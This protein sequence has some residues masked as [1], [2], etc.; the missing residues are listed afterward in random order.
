MTESWRPD[1]TLP[2]V[3]GLSQGADTASF[4]A[5]VA[6]C[7]RH[8]GSG[9][10][11][12]R[13]L[14]ALGASEEVTFD[15]LSDRAGRFANVLVGRGVR[16]GDRV[17]GLIPRIPDLLTVILGTLRVGA[18]YQ[19][20]FTAFGPKAIAS[21]LEVSCPRLVV[22]DGANRSKLAGLPYP[23]LTIDPSDGSEGLAGELAS[24]DPNFPP[25]MMTGADPFLMMFTSG[26]T[27]TPK[28]VM[29]PNHMLRAVAS[30]IHYGLDLRDND[31][32]WNLADPGWAY[33][34]YYG[35]LGP[36]LMGNACT[37]S[38][39]TFSVERSYAVI[40]RFGITNL[41][42]APTAYRQM[43]ANPI[44]PPQGVRV[45]SSAGETLDPE[46]AQWLSTSFACPA[47]DHFGQTEVG[48]VLCDHHGLDQPR[49]PGTVGL[50]VPGFHV[51]VVSRNGVPCEAGEPGLLAV[52]R[53]SPLFWFQGYY[54]GADA[55]FAGDYYLTGDNARQ[56][57]DGTFRFVG[58]EDDVITSSGY[59]IGPSEV[60]NA[61]MEH[62]AVLDTAVI[63]K[64]DPVRT[65]L[66]K[67]FVVLKDGFLPSDALGE[68]IGQFVKQRLAAHAYPREISFVTEL[69]KTASGKM[70][71]FV[72]R[73]REAEQ[74]CKGAGQ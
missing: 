68:E 63:G 54:E 9:R 24:A 21:R 39:A 22:T 51:A 55:P 14:S 62:P 13:W 23:V 57:P 15:T 36:L 50:A 42:G 47:R 35:V 4:N 65:E 46:T 69:P 18:V 33:G 25:A 72:L 67:A 73:A 56:E 2:P 16:A 38:E 31:R 37:L 74:Q 40:D 53:R 11:G 7:D 60:E 44:A 71:R 26:T 64:P 66:V 30:Y 58:R 70:Q 45:V 48:M 52:D 34:L 19:P 61:L 27:G 5:C 29:V 10:V 59:R 1:L 3:D 17:A 6:L 32:F 49:S 43:A 8:A 12:L 28:G 41:A 20:L